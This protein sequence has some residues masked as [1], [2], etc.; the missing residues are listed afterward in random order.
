MHLI[1]MHSVSASI[2]RELSERLCA[3]LNFEVG[4]GSERGQCVIGR[5][6]KRREEVQNNRYEEAVA[7]RK[8]GR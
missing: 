4:K 2:L 6:R 1:K 3:N 5:I 8:V 7:A